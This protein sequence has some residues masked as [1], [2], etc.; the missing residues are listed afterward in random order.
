MINDELPSISQSVG[1]KKPDDSFNEFSILGFFG[2]LNYTYKERYLLELSGRAD[3]SSKFPRGSRW[4]FFPSASVGWRIMEEP[5]ME[6]L[7]EYIPE[8]KIRASYGEVGNQN[9]SAYAFI[10]S[11]GSYR[12]S[13]LHDNQQPITLYSPD[14]VSN[15]F[16][17]ERVQSFNICLLYT[18]PSPRD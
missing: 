18:S 4:G 7:R 5:F 17:W 16:T 8:F 15:S 3:A 2:R 6:S 10:P 14:I 9:I 12:S 11:M 13:W 1:E